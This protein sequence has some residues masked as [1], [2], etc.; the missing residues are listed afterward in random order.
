MEED[1]KKCE[2]EKKEYLEGWKRAKA[3]LINY[4]KEETDRIANLVSY[5][6]EEFIQEMILI[7]DNLEIAEKTISC[8]NEWSKGFLNIKKQIFSILEKRG[9]KEIQTQDQVF[10][11]NFH[12]AIDIANIPEKDSGI[13]LEELQKGYLLKDK[14]I[15]P[16]KVKINK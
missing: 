16:A 2:Q 5:I 6:Q 12:E 8:E 10:D 9:V 1:L 11:P 4:K 14:V 15:R 13:I 7:L 3:D